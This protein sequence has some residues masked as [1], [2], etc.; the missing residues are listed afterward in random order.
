MK[1]K[2]YFQ[3]INPCIPLNADSRKLNNNDQ[4]MTIVFSKYED[5]CKQLIGIYLKDENNRIHLKIF[6]GKEKAQ[7][8]F[9][10]LEGAQNLLMF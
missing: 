6:N 10:I 2:I 5:K 9:W 7:Q 4:I 8:D 1:Q 3:E